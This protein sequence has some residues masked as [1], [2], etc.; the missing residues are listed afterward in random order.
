MAAIGGGYIRTY[1]NIFITFLLGGIWH[2]ASWMFIIWGTMHGMAMILHRVWKQLGFTMNKYLA[3]FITFNFINITW[4][5]F[6]AK[7]MDSAL[8]VLDGMVGMSGITFPYFLQSLLR[9]LNFNFGGWLFHI[10]DDG[11]KKL[12]I[13]L[14]IAFLSI[15]FRRNIKISY[16][17]N[18]YYVLLL[19]LVSIIAFL[20]LSSPSEFLYFNF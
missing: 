10:C 15:F 16:I 7:D 2:G 14:T 17:I 5:F 8:K 11:G 4:V 13:F 18:D 1:I 9:D 20:N 6:R 3:W 19:L 12:S